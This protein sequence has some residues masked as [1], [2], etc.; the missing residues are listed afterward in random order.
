M[1]THTHALTHCAQGLVARVYEATGVNVTVVNPRVVVD[2]LVLLVAA[3][4]AVHARESGRLKTTDVHTEI[5]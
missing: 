1:L 3:N 4:K 2:E 5:L